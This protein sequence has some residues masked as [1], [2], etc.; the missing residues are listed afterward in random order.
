MKSYGKKRVKA[1][2]RLS[3]FLDFYL[4]TLIITLL[5]IFG[6]LWAKGKLTWL[7]FYENG[8]RVQLFF[9]NNIISNGLYQAIRNNIV[10]K[11]TTELL[12]FFS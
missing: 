9:G 3:T 12:L 5:Y 6:P 2:T 1:R 8:E 4:T 7:T 11:N 10:A